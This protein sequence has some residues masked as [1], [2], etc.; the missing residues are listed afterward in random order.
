MVGDPRA[1][2]WR[3]EGDRRGRFRYFDARGR[4]ITDVA[5]L[6]RLDALRIPPAWTDVRIAPS[7]QARL[8]AVGRDQKGRPQYVYHAAWTACR[9]AAKYAKLLRFAAALPGFR[10]ATAAH[11]AEAGPTRNRVLALLTRL[12]DAACFRIGDERYRANGTFGVAT[13]ETRHLRVGASSLAFAF[14]GKH[15][16]RHRK[17]VADPALA[18]LAREVRAL[19]GRRLFQFRREDG[20]VAPLR[21]R[22]VNAYIKAVMGAE[23][24]AKDFRTWG[25]TLRAAR[26]L[27]RQG[28][29]ASK[30]AAARTIRRCVAEV[31]R[32]L[33]NTPAI[34]R[35]SYVSPRVLSAY[36]AGRTL[37]DYR[38][39]DAAR[40]RAFAA[41]Y[42][43]EEMALVALLAADPV[44]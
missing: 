44:S 20:V 25:G 35:A 28:P 21:G 34:C 11:L 29:A 36:Q 6:A 5:A 3:R 1:R 18:A 30:A 41:G 33:G 16:I 8:Q 9:A 31:A 2:W 43:A 4:R 39:A 7:P 22:D 40:E 19:P 17:I 15:G 14:R 32:H 37:R 24:S 10:A 27:D 26:W 23:F 38:P 13:L 42:T 12:L